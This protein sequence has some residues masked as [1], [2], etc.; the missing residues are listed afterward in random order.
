MTS[1]RLVP[2]R[3]GCV[4]T[5]ECSSDRCGQHVIRVIKTLHTKPSD[6]LSKWDYICTVDEA[7]VIGCSAVSNQ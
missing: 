7:I 3:S 1:E 5:A 4:V 2:F 6:I